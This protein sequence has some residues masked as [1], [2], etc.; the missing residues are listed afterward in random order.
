MFIH[1]VEL[2]SDAVALLLLC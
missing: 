2:T 1:N